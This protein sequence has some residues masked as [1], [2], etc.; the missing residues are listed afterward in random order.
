[1]AMNNILT[2]A[3]RQWVF[4]Q[5][6]FLETTQHERSFANEQNAIAN[7]EPFE[8]IQLLFV[9]WYVV[10]KLCDKSFINLLFKLCASVN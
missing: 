3:I 9:P 8:C 4:Q 10:Y 2:V 6:A 5:F 7:F 1:M